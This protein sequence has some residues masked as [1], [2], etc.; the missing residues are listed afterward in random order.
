[1]RLNTGKISVCEQLEIDWFIF[2]AMRV[3]ALP[4]DGGT[5]VQKKEC[6]APFVGNMTQVVGEVTV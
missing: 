1:M 4:V 5:I 6:D 2:C 3:T